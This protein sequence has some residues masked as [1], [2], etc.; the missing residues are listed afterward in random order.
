MLLF[1]IIILLQGICYLH[2]PQL[3]EQLLQFCRSLFII[4]T[5]ITTEFVPCDC[6]RC[7]LIKIR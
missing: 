7:A 6:N 2:G 5:H 1:L 3:Q 4:Y